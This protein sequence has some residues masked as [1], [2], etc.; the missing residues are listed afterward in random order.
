MELQSAVLVFKG[1]MMIHGCLVTFFWVNSTP[2]G[3]SARV[4]L[5]LR[6][7]DRRNFRKE[8]NSFINCID[9]ACS[10]LF[11]QNVVHTLQL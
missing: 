6:K 5:A 1:G 9:R 8:Q 7:A 10:L 4:G 11:S 3:I 2:F